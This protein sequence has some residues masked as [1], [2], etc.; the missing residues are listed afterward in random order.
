MSLIT[1]I[2]ETLANWLFGALWFFLKDRT[3]DEE[4]L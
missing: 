1:R 4:D 3:K 2:L